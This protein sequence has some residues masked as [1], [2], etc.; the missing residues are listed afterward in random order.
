M[1]EWT[2][3][4]DMFWGMFGA[5]AGWLYVKSQ[6]RRSGILAVLV[7]RLCSEASAAGAQF[8]HHSGGGVP[9]ALYKRVAIGSA[10]EIGS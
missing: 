1:A 8:L 6:F 7:A 5:E 10:A 3:I 2:L 4:H 9:E